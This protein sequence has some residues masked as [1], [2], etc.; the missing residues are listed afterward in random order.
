MQSVKAILLAAGRGSRMGQMTEQRPKC[1]TELAGKS[2]LD[3]QLETLN[4]VGISDICLVTGYRAG[5]LNIPGACYR[6]NT[7]WASSNMVRSLF[8]ADDLLTQHECVVAYT[9]ILYHPDHINLL[10]TGSADVRITYDSDWQS[11]W[12]LRFENPLEDAENF[13]QEARRLQKIG[14][15]AKALDDIQGQYMGLLYITPEG[16]RQ[17]KT[18]LTGVSLCEVNLLDMT[19]LLSR[20][21][22]RQVLVESIAVQGRWC[23]IDSA[24]DLALYEQQ[25]QQE[26]TGWHYDW[27]GN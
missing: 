27:R 25:L 18:V 15:S 12:D 5:M 9:D 17:I 6:H 13:Q 4:S 21:L 7:F 24:N 20:L 11:L 22:E 26:Q 8:A 16:W 1:L 14:G 23:E 3:W 19:A 2:L 10:L